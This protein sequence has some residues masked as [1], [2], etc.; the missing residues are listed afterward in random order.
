MNLS[1]PPPPQF[2]CTCR[3]WIQNE[4]GLVH[5]PRKDGWKASKRYGLAGNKWVR[6]CV[7]RKF[8][9]GLGI[10]YIFPYLDEEVKDEWISS[11]LIS[12]PLSADTDFSCPLLLP[13]LLLY[14]RALESESEQKSRRY[15]LIFFSVWV[16]KGQ[17]VIFTRL[18]RRAPEAE[19]S[20][21]NY[22]SC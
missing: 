22:T 18:L 4:R 10:S 17:Q 20:Y 19:T 21:A 2:K 13:L 9:L 12:S 15:P 3:Y 7:K 14:G 1:R 8:L 5:D 6:W 11:S 16:R